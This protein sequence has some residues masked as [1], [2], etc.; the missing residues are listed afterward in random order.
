MSEQ[1]RKAMPLTFALIG[2]K[3]R[4]NEIYQNVYGQ[5]PKVTEAV[6]PGSR[7]IK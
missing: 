1:A 3:D 4:Y 5:P 2:G 6:L 7:K